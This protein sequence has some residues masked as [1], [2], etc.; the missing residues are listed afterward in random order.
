MG[1]ENLLKVNLIPFEE[2]V[3]DGLQNGQT[4]KFEYCS[5]ALWKLAKLFL[6]EKHGLDEASP[7]SVYAALYRLNIINEEELT[8][9]R[10]IVDFR[11]RLSHLYKKAVF[12]KIVSELPAAVALLRSVYQKLTS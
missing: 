8:R 3:R 11:N 9:L 6:Y 10:E 7:K 5:E 2:I 4:Q 12:E 1:L